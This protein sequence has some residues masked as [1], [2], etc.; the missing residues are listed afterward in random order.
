MNHETFNA[1]RIMWIMVQYDLP[2]ETRKD[3]K[4]ADMFRKNLQGGG[5]RMFQF[6]M[7]IRHCPS[8]ESM[9]MHKSRVR[10]CLPP[11]GK[12]CMFALTDKQFENIEFYFG[13]GRTE[14]P[15]GPQQLMLF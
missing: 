8:K 9:E 6:S 13:D 4:E 12:V 14:P 15:Q 1:F 11:K 7:Y 5:F 3:R 10:Q 2:T